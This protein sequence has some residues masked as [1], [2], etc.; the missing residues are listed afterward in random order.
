MKQPP[1][2]ATPSSRKPAG[3]VIGRVVPRSDLQEHC[4][5]CF[6]YFG[7]QEQRVSVGEKTVHLHCSG[8]LLAESAER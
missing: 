3:R 5:V 7:S 1:T 4:E 2:T 6:L 8:R